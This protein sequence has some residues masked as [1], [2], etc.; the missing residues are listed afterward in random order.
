MKT[1]GIIAEYNPFHLGHKYLMDE[2]RIVTDAERIV[3]VMSGNSV[4]RGDFAIVDKFERAREAVLSGADL[5]LEMPFC[6]CSQSAEYFAQGG[7]SILHNLG[8]VDYICYG[9][10]HNDTESQ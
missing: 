8:F 6:Y 10:E 2:L 4:Q 7:T 1:A 5:V 9:S 3:V